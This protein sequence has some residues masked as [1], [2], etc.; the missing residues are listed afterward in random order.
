M[1]S[2]GSTKTTKQPLAQSDAIL[3]SFGT[4]EDWHCKQNKMRITFPEY[5]DIMRL[6]KV[7]WTY[8]LW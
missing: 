1:D 8:H 4:Q 2:K 7:G 3:E 5:V 6:E